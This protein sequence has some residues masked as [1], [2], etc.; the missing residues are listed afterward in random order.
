M[1]RSKVHPHDP[2]S[3]ALN[4]CLCN[5]SMM[6]KSMS[7]AR[8]S[9]HNEPETTRSCLHPY[10]HICGKSRRRSTFVVQM[11][12]TRHRQARTERERR[13][14]NSG[15]I[16]SCTLDPASVEGKRI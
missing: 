12:T 16:T 9:G 5:I 10:L 13:I 2:V 11:L 7:V 8:G 15:R 4:G 6:S 1:I 14:S 3:P